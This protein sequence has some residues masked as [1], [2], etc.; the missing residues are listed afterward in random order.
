MD[1]AGWEQHD[2]LLDDVA[3]S[4]LA[5]QGDACRAHQARGRDLDAVQ[6]CPQASP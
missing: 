4:Q 1:A 3:A 2:V 5:G 6:A